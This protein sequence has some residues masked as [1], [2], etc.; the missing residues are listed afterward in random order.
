MAIL[1]VR[2]LSVDYLSDAPS[3]PLA[4][5]RPATPSAGQN[6]GL[7]NPGSTVAWSYSPPRGESP[8]QA[9]RKATGTSGTNGSP[10]LC[11]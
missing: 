11:A 6:R 4:G 8:R 9:G 5:R 7:G 10:Q 2:N 1:E 3:I